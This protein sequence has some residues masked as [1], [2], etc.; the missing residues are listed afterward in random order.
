LNR[1]A[2]SIHDLIT[3][4][5]E[6]VIPGPWK[7]KPPADVRTYFRNEAKGKSTVA[8]ELREPPGQHSAPSKQ[9]PTVEDQRPL[10]TGR[11]RRD[12]DEGPPPAG[13]DKRS[14]N[15]ESLPPGWEKEPPT[16][17][18]HTLWAIILEARHG[19]LLEIG[20]MRTCDS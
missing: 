8:F 17:G 12:T 5:N 4:I 9:E 2:E 1:S 13:W 16:K 10:P 15:E 18:G 7:R 11:E 3:S 19:W 14:S 6:N 20:I